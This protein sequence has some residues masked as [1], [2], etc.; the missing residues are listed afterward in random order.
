MS[1]AQS[2][3]S[4]NTTDSQPAESDED[5]YLQKFDTENRNTYLTTTHPECF[6]GNSIEVESLTKIV[7]NAKNFI[8]DNNH[9]TNPFLSKYERTKILGQ[10][11]KQLNMG[12]KPFVD[13]PPNIIDGYLIAQ[14]ELA[15][16]KIPVIIRRPIPNG[17]SEYWKLQDLEVL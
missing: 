5:D 7:R 1:D 10:R 2:I 3:D 8:I 4:D 12:A 17:K 6:T 13:V 11:A 16:K 14:L 9:K 15:Q